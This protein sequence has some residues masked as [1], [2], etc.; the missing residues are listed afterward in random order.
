M[1]VS[2]RRRIL[3]PTNARPIQFAPLNE[4]SKKI[5]TE[6]KNLNKSV[7]IENGLVSN[8][9]GS[10]YLET[11]D[12]NGI[13]YPTLLLTSVYGPR[14]TRGSFNSKASLTIQF[15]EV[16]A[17][18][19][20]TGELKELC[21][22]L[23]NIFNAVINLAGYPKSGIDIFLNLIQHEG[24]SGEYSREAILPTCIN[25]ITL[26]LVDA[27]IEIFDMVSAGSYNGTVVSFT[28]NGEEIVGLWKDTGDVE[29]LVETIEKCKEQYYQ[30]R[31]TM[32]KYLMQNKK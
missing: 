14:P 13:E 4:D 11:R 7:F 5:D 15:K 24:P 26:A 23:T 18:N 12:S 22:F 21:N 19:F 3:G 32:I 10:S 28:K 25:G 2:D 17:E 9:N 31:S 27:G 29:D 20:P 6:R 8:S 1:S 16:T 30:N